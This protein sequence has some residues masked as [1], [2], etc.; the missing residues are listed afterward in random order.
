ML[1]HCVF[2]AIRPDVSQ[3][4]VD[5]VMSRLRALSTEVPGMGSFR[6][7]PNRDYEGK[8]A[9]W[10]FGFIITF[11]DRAAH[12]QY[13]ANPLHKAAGA[14]LCDLCVGGYAGIT[15]FDLET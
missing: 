1:E 13:D 4:E 12:L 7:G 10:T 5:A 11:T 14:A 9:A 3:D 2:C 6:A 8:S 15:V